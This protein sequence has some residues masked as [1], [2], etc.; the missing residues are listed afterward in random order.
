MVQVQTTLREDST[1]KANFHGS[2]LS[3]GILAGADVSY[4][5]PFRN[6]IPA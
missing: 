6:L 1:Y 3:A 2:F 5:S 4:S